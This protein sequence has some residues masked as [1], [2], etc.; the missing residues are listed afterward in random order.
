MLVISPH[1][2]S[3]LSFK[4][5]ITGLPVETPYEHMGLP[6]HHDTVKESTD[7]P[8][9][10]QSSLTTG[11]DESVYATPVDIQRDREFN[12]QIPTVNPVLKGE[13]WSY[14]TNKE[15]KAFQQEFKVS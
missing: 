6:T 9:K 4:S 2:V 3:L 14:V 10:E 7:Y 8:V 5:I 12:H 11:N 13:L 1:L 15:I